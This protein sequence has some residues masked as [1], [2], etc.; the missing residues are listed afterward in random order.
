MEIIGAFQAPLLSALLSKDL[1]EDIHEKHSSIMWAT[2]V[3]QR[4]PKNLFDGEYSVLVID[5]TL[6][7]LNKS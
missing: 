2:Q 1:S 4:L 5:R 6:S 7:E 3:F